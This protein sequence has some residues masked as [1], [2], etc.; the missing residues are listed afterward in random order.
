[1]EHHTDFFDALKVLSLISH[2]IQRFNLLVLHLFRIDV[3]PLWCRH[4]SKGGFLG[5][6]D[7]IIEV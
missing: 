2:L 6:M 5:F 1:M 7:V 4:L 3:I